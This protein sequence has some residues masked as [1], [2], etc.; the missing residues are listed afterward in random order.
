ML[1]ELLTE[2]PQNF[3]YSASQIAKAYVP[4]ELCD[5]AEHFEDDRLSRIQTG[6]FTV[7]E[8]RI[9]HGRSLPLSLARR[10]GHLVTLAF[11]GSAVNAIRKRLLVGA[12]RYAV[13]GHGK[14]VSRMHDLLSAGLDPDAQAPCTTLQKPSRPRQATTTS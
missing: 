13:Q 8:W 11:V 5:V 1:W 3:N 12:T 9:S 6:V 10:Q 2:M 7:V 4:P 14:H